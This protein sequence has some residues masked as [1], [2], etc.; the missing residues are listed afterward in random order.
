[1]ISN[2][3]PVQHHYKVVSELKQYIVYELTSS[4]N[5]KILT[6]KIRIEKDRQYHN[7]KGFDHWLRIRNTTNW[8]T[9]KV[10][11]GL[12]FTKHQ[13]IFYGDIISGK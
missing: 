11:T 13:T 1:M 6:D 3:E 2:A 12:K 8:K 5:G 4:V 9:S 7:G 10:I